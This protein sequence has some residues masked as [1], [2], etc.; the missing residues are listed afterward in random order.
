MSVA[1]IIVLA[2]KAYGGAGLLSALAF[3]AFGLDRV[4]VNARGAYPF[5]PLLIP[6]LV[7]LWPLVLVRW[8]ALATTPAEG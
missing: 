7:L 4:D 3:L 1:E 6:G 5:R 8:R 2:A